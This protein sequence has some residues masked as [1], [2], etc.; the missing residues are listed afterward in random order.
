VLAKIEIV[1]LPARVHA[2]HYADLA[3]C[4][5]H[6]GMMSQVDG[7][8]Q[9]AEKALAA[10]MDGDDVVYANCRLASIHA[11]MGNEALAST[12]LARAKEEAVSFAA[13]QADLIFK[14]QRVAEIASN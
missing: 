6:L 10:E 4:A 1:G 8:I 12:S 2:V 13:I 9:L 14:L 11:A 5:L 3:T 7:L